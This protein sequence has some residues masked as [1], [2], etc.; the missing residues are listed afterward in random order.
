MTSSD[1]PSSFKV[2][3]A[4]PTA[5]CGKRNVSCRVIE[6]N[7]TGGESTSRI[8]KFQCSHESCAKTF[9]TA[10]RL[11][12]HLNVH[13]ID[14]PFFCSFC[15]ASFKRQYDRNRHVSAKHAHFKSISCCLCRKR[16][17]RKDA[18]TRHLKGSDGQCYT[19]LRWHGIN[20][21]D[22]VAGN[23]TKEEIDEHRSY[24]EA[25]QEGF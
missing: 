9:D 17:S 21:K 10:N 13:R 2:S 3:S 5:D 12:S 15:K 23:K 11:S 24:Y 16:Y 22:I 6:D 18:L 1:N 14:K 20:V 19:F 25:W 4:R 8:D 7:A